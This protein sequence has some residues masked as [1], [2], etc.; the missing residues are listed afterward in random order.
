M[1]DHHECVVDH[2]D[3]SQ[4]RFLEMWI[5]NRCPERIFKHLRRR[6][7]INPMLGSVRFVL[8]T[9]PDPILIQVGRK[10]EKLANKKLPRNHHSVVASS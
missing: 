6:L 3:C 1:H 7:K 8:V 2:S 5:L 4:P 9:I 10:Q